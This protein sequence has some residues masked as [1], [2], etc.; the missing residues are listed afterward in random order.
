[1]SRSL[2]L[3]W[4]SGL[5]VLLALV[6]AGYVEGRAIPGAEAAYARVDPEMVEPLWAAPSAP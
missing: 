3:N 1:M 6:F 5:V 4:G 2:R